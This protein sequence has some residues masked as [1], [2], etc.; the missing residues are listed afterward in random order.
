[1]PTNTEIADSAA[2]IKKRKYVY[3]S[4]FSHAVNRYVNIISRQNKSNRNNVAVLTQLIVQGGVLHPTELARLMWMPKY[5]MTKIIDNLEANGLVIR[6]RVDEDRRAILI[7]VTLSGLEFMENH[8][9]THDL[10]WKDVI[11]TLSKDEQDELLKLLQ[12]MVRA[13]PQDVINAH[14]F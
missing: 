8:L 2:L 10:L 11:N 4:A 6:Q 14:I 5:S 9:S 13:F 3:I 1:L 7:K 12:K